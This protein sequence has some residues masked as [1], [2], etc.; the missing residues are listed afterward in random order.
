MKEAVSGPD[1]RY[2]LASPTIGWMSLKVECR[3][4][5]PEQWTYLQLSGDPSQDFEQDIEISRG[6]RVAGSVVKPDGTPA[7][8]ALVGRDPG[9]LLTGVADHATTTDAEGNFSLDGV[10]A[11]NGLRL[12]AIAEGFGLTRSDKSISSSVLWRSKSL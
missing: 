5:Y 9:E 7:A 4:D 6:C 8:G 2:E 12:F 11:R 1:G 3:P 10:P